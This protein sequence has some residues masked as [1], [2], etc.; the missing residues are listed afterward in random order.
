[1]K[2]FK[3][4]ITE[5]KKKSIPI[6][7]G[8]FKHKNLK[9]NASAEDSN[10]LHHSLSK[11]YN[12]YTD[13]HKHGIHQYTWESHDMNHEL[14]KNAGHLDPKKHVAEHK[15]MKKTEEFVHAHKTPH[16]MYVYTGIHKAHE[17]TRHV[18]KAGTDKPIEIHHHGY[19]S[20]SLDKHIAREFTHNSSDNDKEEHHHIIKIHVPKGH[21]G[22]YIAHHSVIDSGG[23]GGKGSAGEREKEFVLP[24]GIKLHVHPQP[25][26]AY[27]HKGGKVIHHVTWHAKVAK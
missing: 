6:R 18:P 4:F 7:L 10:K 12:K 8:L 3:E 21:H 22:A 16:D 11:Y 25:T 15:L 2:T 13:E 14:H 17:L 1:M 9:E 19:T 27:Q 23:E 24:K 26:V 20:T 5:A